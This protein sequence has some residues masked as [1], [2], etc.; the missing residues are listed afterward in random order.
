MSHF[1]LNFS[2]GELMVDHRAS[3]GLTEEQATRLYGEGHQHDLLGEG[4]VYFTPTRGCCHC[5]GCVVMNPGRTRHRNHCIKCHSYICDW[6]AEATKEPDYIH[7][8]FAMIREMIQSGKW[9]FAGGSM[10]NPILLPILQGE[11]YG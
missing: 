5:G 10:S 3:P 2:E 1:S 4:R 7:R 6:C 11:S 8:P 9:R